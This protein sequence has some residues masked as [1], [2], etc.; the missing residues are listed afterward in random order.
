MIAPKKSMTLMPLSQKEILYFAGFEFLKSQHQCARLEKLMSEK[1][2]I[3][4]RKLLSYIRKLLYI[5]KNYY[6]YMIKLSCF[7]NELY[8]RKRLSL[9]MRFHPAIFHPK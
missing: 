7:Y 4:I 8:C 3:C 6:K 5:Y 9:L 1:I 2:I